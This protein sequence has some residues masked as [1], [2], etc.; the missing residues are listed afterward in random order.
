MS[1][2][3]SR[4]LVM[5]D[6]LGLTPELVVESGGERPEPRYRFGVART[7][8]EVIEAWSMVY[9]VYVHNRFIFPHAFGYHTSPHAIGS[10]AVV[11]AHHIGQRLISTLTAMR[12]TVLGLPLDSLY[13]EELDSLRRDG[14]VLTEAGLLADCGDERATSIEALFALMNHSIAYAFVGD[15]TD[16]ICGVHPRH[17]RFYQKAYGFELIGDTRAYPA[18]N[19][20]P[21]VLI[22]LAREVL[23]QSH[24]LP[25]GLVSLVAQKLDESDFLPRFPFGEEDQCLAEFDRYLNYREVGQVMSAMCAA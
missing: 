6:R 14:R 1:A 8:E 9:R 4:Q 11:I 7:L 19:N 23:T 16:L 2:A 15:G 13:P 10:H 21:C 17:A 5:T 12:D 18:V 22:R 3:L 25:R 24:R 20:R